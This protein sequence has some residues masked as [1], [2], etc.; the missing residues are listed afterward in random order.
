MKILDIDNLAYL[1][2]SKYENL[3]DQILELE[4]KEEIEF[5]FKEIT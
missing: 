2:H 1:H 5:G 4:S 3:I